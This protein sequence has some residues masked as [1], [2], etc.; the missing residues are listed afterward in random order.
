M[1]TLLRMVA[2]LPPAF[3]RFVF[4]ARTRTTADR[5]APRKKTVASFDLDSPYSQP[6]QRPRH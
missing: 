5:S 6:F 1:T 3:S 4:G 2:H